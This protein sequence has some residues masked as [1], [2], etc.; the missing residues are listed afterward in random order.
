MPTNQDHE[1]FHNLT[2]FNCKL[3]VKIISQTHVCEL[4]QKKNIKRSLSLAKLQATLVPYYLRQL[5]HKI[6]IKLVG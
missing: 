1:H 6:K 5:F 4:R 2:I 3:T